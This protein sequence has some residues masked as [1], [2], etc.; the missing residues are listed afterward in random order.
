M[1]ANHQQPIPVSLD[2]EQWSRAD[3]GT[4]C[5]DDDAIWGRRNPR[6]DAWC[7]LCRRGP[8]KGTT[9]ST[10]QQQLLDLFA[11]SG[12]IKTID[13]CEIIQRYYN[14]VF[15]KDQG[16][17]NEWTLRGIFNHMMRH[18]PT[19]ETIAENTKLMHWYAE[20]HCTQSEMMVLDPVSG[21]LRML[22]DGVGMLM[23]LSKSVHPYLRRSKT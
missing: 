18:R 22:R 2:L 5:A 19:D 1:T 8:R 14:K 10:T 13:L 16:G 15:R 11:Q 20:L 23:K 12:T 17:D 21:R 6:M 7:F 3:D 9:P 4:E